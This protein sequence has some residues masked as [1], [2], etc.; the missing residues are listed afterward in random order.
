[1]DYSYKNVFL[2]L[3]KDN[4]A[5]ENLILTILA[6]HI[7]EKLFNNEKSQW[8]MISKKAKKWIRQNYESQISSNFE[9]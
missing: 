7:L 4:T 1:M 3:I 6:L 8:E 2:N 5:D 9:K